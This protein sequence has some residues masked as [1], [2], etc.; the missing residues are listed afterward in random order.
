MNLIP[1]DRQASKESM[2]LSIKLC[3]AFIKNNNRNLIIY[4]EGTRSL[5]GELQPF[6]KGPAWIASKL[7]LPIVPVYI[8]GS[9][10]SMPKRS[11]FPKTSTD[12]R[13]DR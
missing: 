7:N 9:Y 6:K 11:I 2:V 4:P 8:H 5:D 3:A 1:I 13:H 10:Q 12:Y